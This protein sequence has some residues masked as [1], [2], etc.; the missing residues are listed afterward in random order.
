MA[1]KGAIAQIRQINLVYA[2][3]VDGQTMSIIADIGPSQENP[4]R[5]LALY[6]EAD[7]LDSGGPNIIHDVPIHIEAVE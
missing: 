7:V 4:S 1:Q 6:S 3:V 2:K 5:N